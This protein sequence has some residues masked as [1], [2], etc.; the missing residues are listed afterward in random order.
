MDINLIVKISARAW[1][2]RILALLYRGVPGR[3]A[4]LLSQTKAGRT[5][6]AQSLQHLVEL[7]LLERNPGHG[8]P[9]RPEY[10]LTPSGEQAAAM[11]HRIENAVPDSTQS[12]LLRKAWSLPVLSLSKV[13]VS[14]GQIKTSLPQI[15]DRALSLSLK[16]LQASRWIATVKDATAPH[17]RAGYQ[18]TGD[19]QKIAVAAL[20]QE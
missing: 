3:Q 19:G 8:H 9:M 5:A 20:L 17:I 14:F 16:H 6:F 18:A 1:S 12:G 7:G 15:T 11:A 2:L 10:R 4:A 13:P